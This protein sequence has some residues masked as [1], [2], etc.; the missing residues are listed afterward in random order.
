MNLRHKPTAQSERLFRQSLPGKTK[1]PTVSYLKREMDREA[2]RLS[3]GSVEES[4]L[5]WMSG[6]PALLKQVPTLNLTSFKFDRARGEVRLQA[7][8]KDF[9]TF[10]K[11]RELFA[12]QF[13]VEQGQLNRSGDLVN[14]SFV[15]K[16]L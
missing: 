9:Q 6:M 1:I 15:L 16:P 14:G 5:D 2:K 10:E 8:S 11:A 4:L 12:G 3:G 7:Q 13:N